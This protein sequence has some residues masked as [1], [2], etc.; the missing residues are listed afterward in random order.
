[1]CKTNSRDAI[2]KTKPSSVPKQ[3]NKHKVVN[4]I[5]HYHFAKKNPIGI[6]DLSES[7]NAGVEK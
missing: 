2:N 7:K 5:M 1:M 6:I 4:I 3:S